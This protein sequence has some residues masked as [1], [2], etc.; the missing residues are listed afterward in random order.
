[1]LAKVDVLATGRFRIIAS[2]AYSLIVTNIN[3]PHLQST[4]VFKR[5]PI[6]VCRDIRHQN[7]GVLA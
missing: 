7:T 5:Y 4:S 2:W 3:L 6:L 1:M